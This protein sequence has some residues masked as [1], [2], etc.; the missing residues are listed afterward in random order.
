MKIISFQ[1]GNVGSVGLVV[2]VI[3]LSVVILGG[4]VGGGWYYQS[5]TSKSKSQN[6]NEKSKVGE[7]GETSVIPTEAE[8]SLSGE[9]VTDTATTT[10]PTA[11]WKTYTNE[12][13]GFNF[14]YPNTYSVLES[15]GNLLTVN[16]NY[17]TDG[18]SM[19]ITVGV[20]S[21][22]ILNF[23]R[24]LTISSG[25]T[26]KSNKTIANKQWKA[27]EY[28][29]RNDVNATDQ[30]NTLNYY[31]EYANKLYYIVGNTKKYSNEI[32]DE[33]VQQI[34]AQILSTFKF[35]E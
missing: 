35:T 10:D 32:T 30:S 24:D 8:E 6:D 12:E 27:Y 25:F 2:L 28:N 22:T 15:K 1:K 11:N 17:P 9:T 34:F 20:R 16:I 19:G 18:L 21:D 29:P 5:Q 7:V 13:Y 26:E 31:L 4:V 3:V 33:E 14:K 23:T